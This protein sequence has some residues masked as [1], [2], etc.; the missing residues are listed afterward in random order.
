VS[1]EEENPPQFLFK[2]GNYTFLPSMV[3]QAHPPDLVEGGRGEGFKKAISQ[4]IF[5]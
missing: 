1:K 5:K 4:V 2:R 3:R